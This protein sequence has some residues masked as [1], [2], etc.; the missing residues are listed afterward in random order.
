MHVA[1]LPVQGG[2]WFAFIGPED[3]QGWESPQAMLEFLG[4]G[5]FNDCGA[6]VGVNAAA[7][8]CEAALKAAEKRRQVAAPVTAGPSDS[9][10]RSPEETSAT[11][12]LHAELSL[13]P[14]NDDSSSNVH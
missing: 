8:I 6:A 7:I 2:Q 10:P 1:L 9:S 4:K 13:V 14:S 12:A 5:Q 11:E 3:R